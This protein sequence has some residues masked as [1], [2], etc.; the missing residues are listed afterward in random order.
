MERG[1]R[2]DPV[3]GRE[4]VGYKLDGQNS[5]QAE[6]MLMS[7]HSGARCTRPSP[8]RPSLSHAPGY[9]TWQDAHKRRLFA[10][11]QTYGAQATL[12]A[13]SIFAR[14]KHLQRPLRV[15]LRGPATRPSRPI[16]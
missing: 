3:S 14:L 4:S 12:C 10:A 9:T 1:A 11:W 8:L 16:A 5:R 15:G 2:R 6:V 13:L 7:A